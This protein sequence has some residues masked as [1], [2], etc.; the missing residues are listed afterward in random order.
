M[1]IYDVGV[2]LVCLFMVGVL[3]L[4]VGC[5]SMMFSRS[6]QIDRM[7]YVEMDCSP[8]VRNPSLS[9]QPRGSAADP[10]RVA[11]SRTWKHVVIH[12][13]ATSGGNAEQFDHQHRRRGWDELGYHF[14][15]GNGDGA[16]DGQVQV[17]SRWRKQKWGAHCG[18]TPG[19][20]YNKYGIGICLVGN[21]QNHMPT[22]A[23]MASLDELLAYLMTTCDIPA[24]S[25]IA[26]KDAPN[27]NTECC[28]R[29]LHRHLHQAMIP[30][31]QNR[32]AK[33]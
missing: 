32:Y 21:F 31:M 33:R 12:H 4:L 1:R 16:P 25:V 8:P 19:N 13:S 9:R 14:V 23:Q 17:G 15:I 22:A 18:G 5:D 27:A 24:G 26:H 7:P 10:W 20:E 30:Q 28:G 2:L 3:G 29:V 6:R 11:T